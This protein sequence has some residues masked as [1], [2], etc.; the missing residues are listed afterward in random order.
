MRIRHY[1]VRGQVLGFRTKPIHHPTSHSREARNNAPGHH[2]VLRGG[3]HHHVA[4][5]GTDHAEIVDHLCLMREKVGHFD[6]GLPILL[7]APFRAK[8]TR[9]RIHVLVLNIAKLSGTLLPVQLVQ[10]WLRVEGFQV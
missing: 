9:L 6:A 4:M 7:E 3:V 5:H 10:Q 8:N 1:D 2:L